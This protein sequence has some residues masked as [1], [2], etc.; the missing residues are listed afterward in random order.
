MW[1]GPVMQ[2]RV[3]WM[4]S[5]ALK[6]MEWYT[7]H[8]GRDREPWSCDSYRELSR[9]WHVMWSG[10]ADVAGLWFFRLE[11]KS[12][13]LHNCFL[14]N[15]TGWQASSLRERGRGPA[16]ITSAQCQGQPP[17]PRVGARYCTGPKSSSQADDNTIKEVWPVSCRAKAG[18]TRPLCQSSGV[19]LE[20]TTSVRRMW[21]YHPRWNAMRCWELHNC[22]LTTE[23][24]VM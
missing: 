3:S 22:Q 6:M 10:L 5:V 9:A 11:L 1:C 7:L 2:C 17:A 23:R 14:A 4:T 15:G 24:W 13:C 18:C 8:M 16:P 20:Y 21:P 12:C 19:L